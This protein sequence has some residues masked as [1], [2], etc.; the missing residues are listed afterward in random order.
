MLQF[1]RWKVIDQSSQ[2][3]FLLRCFVHR[4]DNL[5]HRAE[6]LKEMQQEEV[7]TTMNLKFW[8][9]AWPSE[10]EVGRHRNLISDSQFPWMA[11]QEWSRKH[12]VFNDFLCSW[13][14][15]MSLDVLLHGTPQTETRVWTRLQSP[16]KLLLFVLASVKMTPGI[17]WFQISTKK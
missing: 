14:C 1:W 11:A 5:R 7:S 9:K 10:G 6:I 13:S 12:E 15:C 4:K 2:S 8:P 16:S 17:S 3:C